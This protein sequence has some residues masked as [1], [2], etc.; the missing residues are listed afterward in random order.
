[1]AYKMSNECQHRREEL[2]QDTDATEIPAMAP[3]LKFRLYEEDNVAAIV[4]VNAAVVDVDAAA[5]LDVVN[6]AVLAVDVVEKAAVVVVV[7]A[8]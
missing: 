2:R 5:V 4:V 1:M 3:V 6:A 8:T 7:E